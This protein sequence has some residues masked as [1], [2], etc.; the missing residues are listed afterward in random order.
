VTH[1][2]KI[3]YSLRGVSA[4]TKLL[5]SKSLD[6]IAAL[7]IFIL[8]GAV[9]QKIWGTKIPSGFRDETTLGNFRG[10]SSPAAEAVCTLLTLFRDRF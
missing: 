6:I 1:R 2:I 9:A 10:Q 4:V 8:E 3:A 5:V 7:G